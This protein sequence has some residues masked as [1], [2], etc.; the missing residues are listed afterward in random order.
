[1]TNTIIHSVHKKKTN[2]ESAVIF[3]LVFTNVIVEL[4]TMIG[5][6]QLNPHAISL[7]HWLRDKTCQFEN[8]SKEWDR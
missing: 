1:M 5:G 3:R 7:N 8:S 6:E 2:T 4:N